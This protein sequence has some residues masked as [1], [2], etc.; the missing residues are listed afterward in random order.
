MHSYISTSLCRSHTSCEIPVLLEPVKTAC[1]A[2]VHGRRG[3]KAVQFDI[4][5]KGLLI[6]GGR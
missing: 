5:Q 6:P 2:L 4:K 1:I 3:Q